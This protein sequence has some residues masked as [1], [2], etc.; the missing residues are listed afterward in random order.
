MV[1][2]IMFTYQ[3]DNIKEALQ[4][5]TSLDS[6]LH[7]RDSSVSFMSTLSASVSNR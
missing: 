3:G 5:A 2:L 6:W 4:L 7:V 1:V